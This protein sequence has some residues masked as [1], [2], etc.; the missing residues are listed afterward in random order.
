MNTVAEIIQSLPKES[1]DSQVS[2]EHIAEIAHQMKR[3]EVYM[4][5][6]L[7][8]NAEAAEV[9][10]KHNLSDYRLQKREALRKWKQRFGNKATY[11]RLITVFQQADL[12]TSSSILAEYREHLVSCYAGSPHPS[13][14]GWPQAVAE[15]YIDLPLAEAPP[16]P[17]GPEKGPRKKVV[18][19]ELFE[20]GKSD[21]ERKL[22]LIEGPAGCG[23]TTLTWHACREWAA[24][25]L[26]PE[27]NLLIYL[28]LEDPSLHSPKSLAD[29]IPHESSKMREDVANEIARLSGKGVCFL[30]DAWDEAPYSVQRKGSYV[31]RFISGHSLPHCS[32]IITSRPVAAGSLYPL[33]TARVVVDGFD[34]DRIAQFAEATLGDGSA[35]KKELNKAFQINSRLLGLCNLP[36]NTAIVLYLLQLQTPYSKLP[37]TQTGLFYALVLNLLLRHMQLRTIHG[38]VEIDEFEDM[39]ESVLKRFKSVCALAFHGVIKSKT[40]FA[41]KDLKELGIDP[42]LDTLGLLQAPRQLTE[43][44]PQHSHTFLHYAVQEFLAAYHISKLTSEEQSKQVSQILHNRPLSSVLPFYAGLTKLTNSSVCSTLI[45][46][47]KTPLDQ[48]AIATRMTQ[49]PG[50]ESSDSRKLLLALMNCIYESQNKDICKLVNFLLSDLGWSSPRVSFSGLTLDPMGCISLGYFF[51]N[52]QLDKVCTVELDCMGDIEVEVLMK[53]L[54]QGCMLKETMGVRLSFAAW[55]YSYHGFK[56]ISEA[57]SQTLIVRGLVFAGW[58]H[59]GVDATAPLTCLIEGLCRRP[60]KNFEVSLKNC[61]SWKHTY[62]LILLLAFGNLREL[63]LSFNN[64]GNSLTMSLVAQA[65]KYNRTLKILYMDVCN[66]N[67]GRLQHLGI[68]LQDN[69]TLTFL[70]ISW[71]LF[72][73]EALTYFLK[74]LTVRS[75]LTMLWIDKRKWK[76][77]HSSILEEINELRSKK[78]ITP[79]TTYFKSTGFVNHFLECLRSICSLPPGTYLSSCEHY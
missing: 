42:P 44:G 7:G 9:E 28:S 71:N 73:S 27:V 59:W 32:I 41:L 11:H 79:L 14:L 55:E 54:S 68:A 48:Y 4:A 1:L 75:R 24:G 15:T 50:S 78:H 70:D 5:Y 76:L 56:C 8:E 45:E 72:S 40:Q 61:V 10:I 33:L 17:N 66:I 62:H 47:T 49:N 52:K 69:E 23:K 20:T 13:C 43:R 12:A 25:R 16:Q 53:E 65:L 57:V 37:S 58:N 22:I 3:W 74:K 63:W 31:Y 60:T 26:F 36:I 21:R 30:V 64:I 29:L 77:E 6:L 18:L 46:V 35:A 51:A 38:Q 34:R 19:G 67:D 39:P 2:D